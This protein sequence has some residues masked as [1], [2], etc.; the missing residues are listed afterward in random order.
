MSTQD[1]HFS[2]APE[3]EGFE[4]LPAHAARLRDAQEAS[5]PQKAESVLHQ[6]AGSLGLYG[7]RRLEGICRALLARVRAASDVAS[8]RDD[9]DRLVEELGRVRARRAL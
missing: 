9:L 8:L 3:R 1:W 6:L 5:D 7:Y 2:Q 4:E